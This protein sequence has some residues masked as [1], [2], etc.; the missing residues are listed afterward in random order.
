M[1]VKR[2]HVNTKITFRVP[3]IYRV[4]TVNTLEFK[5]LIPKVIGFAQCTWAHSYPYYELVE[6]ESQARL[7]SYWC[8]TNELDALQFTLTEKNYIRA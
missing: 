4:T 2:L 5:K 8:F 6:E 1:T 7:R 3:Y